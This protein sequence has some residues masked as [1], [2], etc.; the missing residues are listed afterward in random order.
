M[1]RPW[2][3]PEPIVKSFESRLHEKTYI[4]D[5]NLRRRQLNTMQRIALALKRKAIIDEIGRL[6]H[7]LT[8]P[9]EGQKGFQPVSAK[10]FVNIKDAK[11]RL[12]QGAGVSIR[13]L[14]KAEAILDKGSE[15][16]KRRVFEGKTSI[17]HAYTKI[18]RQERHAN[19]RPL[20]EGIFDLFYA[21][22]PWPHYL[23]LRG[24]P[25][26]HY[27][28]MSLEDICNLE[29]DG[30]RI[31]DKIADDA[32]LFLWATNPHLEDAFKVIEA[33]G[34]TYK[35][36]MVW[37]KDKWGTGYYLRGQHEL[38]LFAERGDMPTPL[39]E[40]RPSSVLYAP[41]REHSR[42]P[43]EVYDIIECLY[44]NRRYLELFARPEVRRPNWTYWG[45]ESRP[46]ASS[47]L[48]NSESRE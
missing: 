23:K 44:P 34:F 47:F 40:T 33:W 46:A 24:S 6:K 1:G 45:L 22:P 38:L 2:D 39:E 10:Y 41:V 17:S 13:T 3:I 18:K 26:A 15:T 36:D 35:T 27:D 8:L 11:K 31:Q 16:L 20:P 42:K 14:E 29:V 28:T 4:L 19:P 9:R 30:V 25:D 32:M 48:A 37:V 5:V 43:D 7:S 21:D 12:S